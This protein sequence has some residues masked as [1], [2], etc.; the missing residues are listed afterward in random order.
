MDGDGA[1]VSARCR[2]PA[3][4]VGRRE[5]EV[6]IEVLIAQNAQEEEEVLADGNGDAQADC[7][8]HWS[9]GGRGARKMD[10]EKNVVT[11]A[12][13]SAVTSRESSNVG[14]LVHTKI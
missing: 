3:V 11:C 10:L 7:G 1:E 14:V 5:E 6:L 12:A 2:Q 8:G 13:H 4:T 9:G